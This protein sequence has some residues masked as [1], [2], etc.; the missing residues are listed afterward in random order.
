MSTATR[1]S[2]AL[3]DALACANELRDAL[4]EWPSGGDA[5]RTGLLDAAKRCADAIDRAMRI[6][7]TARS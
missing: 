5:G 3:K 1:Y 6:A 7:E 4:Q 2:E